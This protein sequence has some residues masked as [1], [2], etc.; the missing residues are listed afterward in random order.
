MLVLLALTGCAK[1]RV[2]GRSLGY[3]TLDVV[4][5]APDLYEPDAAAMQ[6]FA[7]DE[8][9]RRAF[10][11]TLSKSARS[12]GRESV[13]LNCVA[14]VLAEAMMEDRFRPSVALRRWVAWRCGSTTPNLGFRFQY[15]VCRSSWDCERALDDGLEGLSQSLNHHHLSFN[16]GIT[17]R[18]RGQIHM[19]VAVS[20][21]REVLLRESGLKRRYLPGE[22]IKL[23][24]RPLGGATPLKAFMDGGSGQVN[25][26]DMPETSSPDW[27]VRHRLPSKPGRYF[28]EVSTASR[29][30]EGGRAWGR[31]LLLFPVYVGIDEPESPEVTVSGFAA[32]PSGD[33]AWSQWLKARYDEERV[34]AGLPPLTLDEKIVGLA[35]ARALLSAETDDLPMDDALSLKLA[36]VGVQTRRW[37]QLHGEFE[38]LSDYLASRLDQPSVRR[39]ITDGEVRRYGVGFAPRT[40]P[41]GQDSMFSVVE[42]LTQ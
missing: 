42:Y 14:S 22:E 1:S 4:R 31:E 26:Y 18:R 11:S 7:P 27:V 29:A 24:L 8:E 35:S 20:A 23:A 21:G 5:E 6:A 38:F 12:L 10:V 13:A 34:R 3:R 28:V 9:F 30:T 39:A 15:N 32:N 41:D 2:L 19:Q 40:S 33:V 37:W 25:V 36:R 16:Y 17:R